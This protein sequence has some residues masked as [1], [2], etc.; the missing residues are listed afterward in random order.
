MSRAAARRRRGSGRGESSVSSRFALECVGAALIG[1][2]LLAALALAAH[3]PDASRDASS[4][5][6]VV[7]AWLG[8]GLFAA[9][10]HA[11]FALVAALAVLG[12]RLLAGRAV[13]GPTSRFW[14]AA[15]ALVASLAA[16]PPILRE[17]LP[18]RFL[19]ICRAA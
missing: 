5:A 14:P 18:G 15:L 3:A 17:A 13:P 8:A 9:L 7:G 6:G 4:R 12:A 19:A 1:T 10:G 16:L 11:G 2:A